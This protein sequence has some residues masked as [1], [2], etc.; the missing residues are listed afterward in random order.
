[1]RINQWASFD[2]QAARA[3]GWHL[4]PLAPLTVLAGEALFVLPWFWLPMVILGARA[5]RSGWRDQLLAWLAAPPI[6]VFAV[7]AAWSS[8]RVLFHW[9]APGYLMLFPLLGR[10]VAICWDRRSV[11]AAIFGTAAFCLVGVTVISSQLQF[12]WLRGSCR[13]KDPTAKG[14]NWTS[15]RND[16]SARGLLHPGTVV[17]V[18]NWR[19]AGKIAYALGRR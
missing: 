11:R 5:F 1:M 13:T 18:P 14:I 6:V 8:Q 12:D 19:D 16:L 10:W 7:I 15:L 3:G 4:H 9:A 2:F 17:G